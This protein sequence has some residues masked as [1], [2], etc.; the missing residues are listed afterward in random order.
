M[1]GLDHSEVTGTVGGVE[2]EYD[3]GSYFMEEKVWG[4]EGFTGILHL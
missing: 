4:A 1:E 2:R 3:L